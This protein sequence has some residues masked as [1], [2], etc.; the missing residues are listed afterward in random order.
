MEYGKINYKEYRCILDAAPASAARPSPLVYPLA[1]LVAV[2]AVAHACPI[3]PPPTP[4][5]L[6]VAPTSK[7][8]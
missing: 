2:E 6:L 4:L 3:A 8:T 7:W 1:L 5:Y